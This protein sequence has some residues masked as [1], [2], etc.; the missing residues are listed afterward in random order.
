MS[1]SPEALGLSVK[2]LQHRHHRAADTALSELGISL[3]QWNALR[4]IDRNPGATMHALAVLTFNSDQAFGTLAIRL[5]RQG[6]IE[7]QIGPG[8]ANAHRLTAEGEAMLQRGRKRVLDIVARSFSP[9][10]Q[11]ERESLMRLLNKLLEH[12]LDDPSEDPLAR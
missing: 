12:G 7:R 1:S 5:L 6:W 2:K 10:S 9:L 3:V 4:E 8:R 11:E